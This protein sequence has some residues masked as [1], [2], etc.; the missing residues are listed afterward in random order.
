M[1]YQSNLR[2]PGHEIPPEHAER[3]EAI[4]GKLR[5]VKHYAAQIF[6]RTQKFT[7]DFKIIRRTL[8]KSAYLSDGRIKDAWLKSTLSFPKYQPEEPAGISTLPYA[9]A[10]PTHAALEAQS[11][12]LLPARLKLWI[13][14]HLLLPA[15]TVM[16][17]GRLVPRNQRSSDVL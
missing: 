12:E 17:P 3:L 13:L 16:I 6:L 15:N 11:S 9:T 7:D 1:A 2:V 4:E 8:E 5:V 14:Q 10:S